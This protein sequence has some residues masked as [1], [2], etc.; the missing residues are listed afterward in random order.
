MAELPKPVGKKCREEIRRLLRS[1]G[2]SEL[3]NLERLTSS[4]LSR[5]RIGGYRILLEIE[6]QA[7][8]LS[9]VD[10]SWFRVFAPRAEGADG[11]GL[12]GG[13][14]RDGGAG[15]RRTF[16]LGPRQD[17]RSPERAKSA[18]LVRCDRWL[19]RGRRDAEVPHGWS[20]Q[21]SNE[22]LG[23]RRWR[24]WYGRPTRYE[25]KDIH[26]ECRQIRERRND[27]IQDPGILAGWL[28]AKRR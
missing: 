9:G 13:A 3:P 22:F 19:P 26:D 21:K 16:R 11:S 27:F 2:T 12:R 10:E 14:K 24:Q 20:P 23:G 5:I 25:D 1:K 7:C 28:R 6:G 18:R 8:V 17:H 15:R 4:P